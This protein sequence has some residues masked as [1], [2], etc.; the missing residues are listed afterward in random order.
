ME[1]LSIR[2]A[3]ICNFEGVY[4]L[5]VELSEHEFEKFQ[6]RNIF[7][8]N[9]N[10]DDVFYLVAIL[11]GRIAGFLSLHFQQLLHHN[12]KV[13]EIQELIVRRDSRRSGIG[14]KLMEEARSIAKVQECIMLEVSCGM[15]REMSHKF[16]R[17]NGLL[18]SHYKFTEKIR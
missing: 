11:D 9:L 18:Q 7:L 3:N 17:D 8:N 1:N 10:S 14:R 16:Y 5:M 2:K 12:G 6:L 15:K 4:D 13:G